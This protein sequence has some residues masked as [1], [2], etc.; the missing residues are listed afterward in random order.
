M[1]PAWKIG[2]RGLVHRSGIQVSKKQNVF[3]TLPRK[4]LLLWG[5]SVP[6][7]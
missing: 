5:A 4:D 3:S 1:L 2:N 6:E 7:K